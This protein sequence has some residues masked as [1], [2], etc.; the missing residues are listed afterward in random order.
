MRVLWLDACGWTL[1]FGFGLSPDK[2]Q[3]REVKSSARCDWVQYDVD[4]CSVSRSRRTATEVQSFVGQLLRDLVSFPCHFETVLHGCVK[5]PAW[6]IGC[7]FWEAVGEAL[8]QE[9]R[10]L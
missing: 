2:F 6:Q 7:L 4:F 9:L 8:L 1:F 10:N 5:L 3:T